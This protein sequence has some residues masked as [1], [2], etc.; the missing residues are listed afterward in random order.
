MAADTVNVEVITQ[1]KK[2]IANLA[3]LAV[4]IYAAK[5]AF[6]AIIKVTKEMVD[7]AKEAAYLKQINMAF[8]SM[9]EAAGESSTEIL[10]SMRELSGGTISTMEMI[11]SANR[12]MILGLP[13]ED[14]DKMMRVARASATATGAG[15]K[16][17]FDDIVVGIGR[18]S[19][20]ILDNLGIIV[21]TEKANQ[22][23][24]EAMGIV[25]RE[26]TDTESRQAFLNATL[27]AGEEIIKKV[28][29][30]G[31]EVTSAEKWQI[32]TAA[33]ADLRVEM[34]MRLLPAFESVTEV[35]AGYARKLASAMEATRELQEIMEK[36]N[37]GN[38]E[39]VK[40]ITNLNKAYSANFERIME[41][42]KTI[43]RLKT[44]KEGHAGINMILIAQLEEEKEGLLETSK[45]IEVESKARRMK[46]ALLD[47]INKKEQEAIDL[48]IE[49]EEAR[50]A[51]AASVAE[52]HATLDEA[53][54]KTEQ[55]AI[56]LKEAE[57]AKFEAMLLLAEN[58]IVIEKLEHVI[59]L[60]KEELEALKDVG[61]AAEETADRQ[62]KAMGRV[63]SGL[64]DRNKL[65]EEIRASRE[66]FE[67]KELEDFIKATEKKAA[68][69]RELVNMFQDIYGSY[70]DMR[71]QGI[72]NEMSAEQDRLDTLKDIYEQDKEALKAKLD[73]GEIDYEAYEAAIKN[74]DKNLATA[75][76][77]TMDDL[78]E[79]RKGILRD[80]A[81]ADKAAALIEIAIN[82][83]AG[84]M[85]AIRQT[86]IFSPAFIPAIIAA[87]AMQAALVAATPIPAFAEGGVVTKPTV[88]LIGEKGPEAV[89]PLTSPG[90]GGGGSIMLQ[91]NIYLG[92]KKIYSD[93]AKAI[94]NK[95]IP[96]YRGALVD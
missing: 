75:Q 49:Q 87:G 40:S 20:M 23:Y 43:K 39:Q 34:G 38:I 88:A 68:I 47:E 5:K 67:A 30:A 71:L 82:T 77:D 16:Q 8:E 60:H 86:G 13:I 85:M 52:F 61:D 9:A 3:K 2:S 33:V 12:A 72:E 28:G 90:I 15:V 25:G 18:Q 24:A 91:N 32:M 65:E 78:E 93:L 66:G 46:G 14:L 50:K 56:E 73:A 74:L 53:Y 55:G 76:G 59:E 94:R 92:T 35:I 69:A 26:L 4:G 80:Q 54:A 81:K 58:P 17:M 44:E 1:V 51:N 62:I 79:K 42:N 96:L 22:D 63:T 31:Q 21:Q 19:R 27:I 70:F 10:E 89:V 83:A 29:K 41:I 45:A 95:Q 64:E 57:I 11:Q 84:V 6:D 48:Q 7:V 36:I 37:E